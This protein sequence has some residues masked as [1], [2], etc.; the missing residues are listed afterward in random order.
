MEIYFHLF[1]P[2]VSPKCHLFLLNGMC[3]LFLN[4]ISPPPIVSLQSPETYVHLQ[5]LIETSLIFN[6]HVPLLLLLVSQFYSQICCFYLF[7]FLHSFIHSCLFPKGV[8]SDVR[9]DLQIFM[10][11]SFPSYT[12]THKSFVTV[13]DHGAVQRCRFHAIATSFHF[14]LYKISMSTLLFYLA[15]VVIIFW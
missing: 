7:H 2:Q 9:V 15:P 4:L 6:Q 11:T 13:L 1:N 14:N 5:L 3:H 12:S 8:F 10:K